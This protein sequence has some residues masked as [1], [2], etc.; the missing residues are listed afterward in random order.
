V[1]VLIVDSLTR[2]Q[3]AQEVDTLAKELDFL[4]CKYKLELKSA[5]QV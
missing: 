1:L 5:R 3:A 4:A 2:G